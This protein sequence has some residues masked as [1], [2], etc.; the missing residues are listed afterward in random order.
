MALVDHLRE[1]RRRLTWS[2]VALAVGIVAAYA[3]WEP[4]YALL[5][6]PYCG[7]ASVKTCT[8]YAYGIFDQFHVRMRVAIIGGAV[9]S[10]PL[11]LYQLGAFITPALHRHERRYAVGFLLASLLLFDTGAGFAY[12]TLSHGLSLLLHV[13]GNGV[14]NLPSLQS[15]LSFVTLVLL[16]FG[17]AFEF[18]V[19]IVFLNVVGLLSASRMRAWRRGMVLA[20][21]GAAAVLTPSTDPFTFLAL[22]LPLC[23]MYEG[24]ILLARLRE[25]SIRRRAAN[26][27]MSTLDDELPSALD[28][29]HPSL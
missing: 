10:A 24:C 11:W 4:I 5:R 20:L 14:T 1:L 22:G 7:V 21:F 29:T 19:L 25:R 16:L 3:L 27:P 28:A 9:G 18:P 12:L 15:Y 26:D 6:Q 23:V 13:A 8:L 17:L 2:L